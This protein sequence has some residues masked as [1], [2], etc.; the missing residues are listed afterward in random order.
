M[1]PGREI[2]TLARAMDHHRQ[3]LAAYREGRVEEAIGHLEQALVL[4]PDFAEGHNNL[5]V[6]LQACGRAEDAAARFERALALNPDYAEAHNNLGAVYEAEGRVDQALFHFERAVAGNPAYLD[7]RN[8]LAMT[9][10]AQGR[11]EA[12][13]GHWHQALA[14]TP[15][16]H[17]AE[18]YMAKA[19]YGLHLAQPLDALRLARTLAAAYAD[20]PVVG[21]AAAAVLGEAPDRATSG[22]VTALFDVFAD[23]FDQALARLGYSPGP[24]VGLLAEDPT[25]GTEPRL[26]ILDAGC[27]TGLAAPFLRPLAKTLTGC[28]LSRKMLARAAATGL[29]DRLAEAE[30]VS[31]LTDHPAAFDVVVAADVF[32]YFGALDPALTALARALRP[33]GRLACSV[34]GGDDIEGARKNGFAVFAGGRY[35]HS[36]RYLRDQAAAAGFELCHLVEATQRWENGKPVPG[37]WMVAQ[38]RP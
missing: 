29:Y 3:G 26:D 25:D 28:D 12:A 30:L 18:I 24:L 9:L 4:A 37:L 6:L 22:Y 1:N 20:N 36:S 34:E 35:K 11:F 23:G 15:G 21:Y 33:G 14:R 7:A 2:G 19:L 27:G 32:V 13:I 16:A 5:G 31:F 8:H 10:F 38:K 17:D